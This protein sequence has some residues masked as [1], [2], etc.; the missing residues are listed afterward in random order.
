MH[1]KGYIYR[2]YH[3]IYGFLFRYY[4]ELIFIAV[5]RRGYHESYLG[6]RLFLLCCCCID[7]MFSEMKG[8]VEMTGCCC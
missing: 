8:Q 1:N 2:V 7:T 4:C 6:C 5:Y 3:P